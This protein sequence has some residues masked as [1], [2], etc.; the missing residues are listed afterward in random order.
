MLNT[1]IVWG[2]ALSSLFCTPLALAK[3]RIYLLAG[4]SNMMGRGKTQEL[5]LIYKSPPPNVR[6][7]YQG[8]PKRLAQN[9]YFGPEVTFAYEV[10]KA[11]PNDQH[12][13][14][15]AAA[16]GSSI[17]QWQRGKPLYYGLLRQ[18]QLALPQYFY[19]R[20]RPVEAIV[21]M[22]GEQDAR[23]SDAFNYQPQ[24]K[25]FIKDLRS[26]I[27]APKSLVVMGKVNPKAPAFRMLKVVQAGQAQAA[28]TLS[29]A[30][31]VSTEG[32]S[33][34]PDRVHYNTYGQMELGRRLAQAYINSRH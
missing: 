17:K 11:F 26:D 7:Y 24:V 22:Q 3:E 34:M 18:L 27:S 28:Q 14:I 9:A 1:K 23:S 10:A 13:I 25:Q 21:W 4:Q 29:N 20:K 19:G 5:P 6:F 30:V 8:R 15:K 33:T 12:I 32:L 31:L 2:I 16:T